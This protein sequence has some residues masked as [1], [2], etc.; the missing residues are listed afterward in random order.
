LQ[1]FHASSIFNASDKVDPDRNALV[2]LVFT[3]IIMGS[4]GQEKNMKIC[5]AIMIQCMCMLRHAAYGQQSE[6]TE[7]TTHCKVGQYSYLTTNQ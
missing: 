2:Y 5:L 6:I 4:Q 7:Q 3:S 1:I